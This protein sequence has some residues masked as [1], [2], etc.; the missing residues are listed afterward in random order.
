MSYGPTTSPPRKVF[1]KILLN[2]KFSTNTSKYFKFSKIF[3]TCRHVLKVPQVY[4]VCTCYKTKT[5]L[6]FNLF[7]KVLSYFNSF[8]GVSRSVAPTTSMFFTHKW[9]L[10]PTHNG[11]PDP[12]KMVFVT[13]TFGVSISVVEVPYSPLHAS[14][15]LFGFFPIIWKTNAH[16]ETDRQRLKG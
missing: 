11:P 3:H 2:L 8:K 12:H 4:W 16:F 13:H 14:K 15:P 5:T 10:W 6:K 7:S 1:L 9:S